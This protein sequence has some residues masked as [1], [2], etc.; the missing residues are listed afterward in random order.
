MSQEKTQSASDKALGRQF[1]VASLNLIDAVANISIEALEQTQKVLDHSESLARRLVEMKSRVDHFAK[2]SRTEFKQQALDSCRDFTEVGTEV[3]KSL[4]KVAQVS[5][6]ELKEFGLSGES[7]LKEV[8]GPVLDLN[9]GR[10]KSAAR[11]SKEATII[12]I[13]IQDN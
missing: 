8:V 6:T 5:L 11:K 7:L 9:L 4:G 1:E 12:P 13:S 2:I 10:R 3:I